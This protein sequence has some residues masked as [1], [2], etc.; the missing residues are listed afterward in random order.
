MYSYENH[1]DERFG[2][3]GF[4]RPGFGFG[5]PFRPYGFGRPYG[6]FGFP[7]LTGFAAG[8]LLTPRPYP[9]PPYVYRPYPYYYP[10]Y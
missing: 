1:T 2:Y 8:A 10:Y 5:R 9:Y 7:F 4:G 6:F 3:G